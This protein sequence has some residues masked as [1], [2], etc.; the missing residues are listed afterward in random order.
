MHE[1]HFIKARIPAHTKEAVRTAAAR[2]GITESIWLRRAICEQLCAE[3]N[4]H[5]PAQIPAFTER[6]SRRLTVR[7]TPQ[8]AERLNFRAT[9]RQTA[10]ATYVAILVRIHLRDA[11]PIPKAELDAL[12][13]T[14]SQTQRIVRALEV[15]ARQP[16]LSAA[17]RQD[18]HAVLRA[19]EALKGRF[20]ELLTANQK[21]WRGQP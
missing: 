11:A 20:Y 18:L 9:A 6:P 4:P 17:S 14:L 12:R 1:T 10:V 13:E 19:C 2:D 5:T 21:S 8:D 16:A 15:M 3:R 7:L